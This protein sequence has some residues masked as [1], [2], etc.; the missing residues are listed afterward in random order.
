M[1]RQSVENL[2]YNEL[3]KL[4]KQSGVAANGKKV[5]LIPTVTVGNSRDEAVDALCLAIWV[6]SDPNTMCNSCRQSSSSV[7]WL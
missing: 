6:A 2:S 7:F 4:C 3:R 5:S 1:D